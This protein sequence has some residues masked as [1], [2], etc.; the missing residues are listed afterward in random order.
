MPNAEG[1]ER[2]CVRRRVRERWYVVQVMAGRE[3]HMRREILRAIELEERLAS[4]R[5]EAQGQPAPPAIVHELF[6]P[7]AR[8]GV[9]R[10][11]VWL[12]GEEVLLP[13]YLI[14]IAEDPARVSAALRR[15]EGFAR[16]VRQDNVFV[17]LPSQ[18]VEWLERQTRRG[19][20]VAGMSE[21]Y[22]QDGVLH[23][24]SGPLMGR[25][26]QVVKVDHRKKRAYLEVEAFGRTVTVQLGLRITRNRD[27]KKKRLKRE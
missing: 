19:S 15:A 24:T 4:E 12:P 2:A 6:V 1:D 11:G 26:A 7:K 17:P 21:G 14:A 3:D 20:S 5:A 22:V 18:S 13:G 8:V 10:D 16:V 23:V 9:N 27:C 25:E